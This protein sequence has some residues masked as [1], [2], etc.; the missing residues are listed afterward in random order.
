MHSV[1]HRSSTV[2]GNNTESAAA[3]LPHATPVLIL[4]FRPCQS[5]SGAVITL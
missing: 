3:E 4:V 2:Q 5:S 1:A